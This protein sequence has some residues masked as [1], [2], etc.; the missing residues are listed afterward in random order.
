MQDFPTALRDWLP[1]VTE[2]GDAVALLGDFNSYGMEDPLQILYADGFVN[3][4]TEFED[5]GYSYS[6]SG[7]SGSL[8]HVLLNEAARE[9]ATGATSLR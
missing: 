1:S 2:Q 4:E 3:V 5:V 8:D 6:F 7:L 9:R